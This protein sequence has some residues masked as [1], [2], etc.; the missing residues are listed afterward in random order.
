MMRGIFL[1]KCFMLLVIASPAW[2]ATGKFIQRYTDW[3]TYVGQSAGNKVCFAVSLPKNSKPTNVR[4]GPIY[5]YISNWQGE[6]VR[7]EISVK[8]GYPFR[9]GVRAEITIGKDKFNLY[10]KDEGAYA[11][12]DD[13]E[14][15]LVSA[16][17][18]G[19]EM[20]VQGR[21]KRGTLTTD[22]YSLAGLT[23]AL[24]HIGKD[25]P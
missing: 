21:S 8:I 15:N 6:N 12:N 1:A 17:Q 9:D 23:A 5:F 22:V 16:M 2:G 13:T 19:N 7:N 20:T 14:K 25:C 11:D 4:R 3:S 24:E 18:N 10:T